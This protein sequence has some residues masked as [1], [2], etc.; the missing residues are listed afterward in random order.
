VLSDCSDDA[1]SMEA[2]LHSYNRLQ[3]ISIQARVDYYR[4][5]G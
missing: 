3:A 1:G 4:T 2:G 5:A